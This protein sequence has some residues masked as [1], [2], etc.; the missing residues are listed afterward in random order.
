MT[1][2]MRSR[3]AALRRSGSPVTHA[4]GKNSIFKGVK[5]KSVKNILGQL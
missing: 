3:I 2:K 5:E 4:I 1:V